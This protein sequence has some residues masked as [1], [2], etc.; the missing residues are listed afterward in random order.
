VTALRW[1]RD[2][3]D[4]RASQ[5]LRYAVYVE[6]MGYYRDTADHLARRW[7]DGHDEAA[8]VLVA[9]VD[10]RDCGTLR[11]HRAGV[12]AIPDSWRDD[13]DL[14]R[15]EAAVGADRV[16]VLTRFVVV[17]SE[18]G[19][20]LPLEMMRETYRMCLGSGVALALIDCVPHLVGLYRRLGFRRYRSGVNDPNT[21][22]LIPMAFDLWDREHLAAL[23]SPL[24]DLAPAD[25]RSSPGI[26]RFFESDNPPSGAFGGLD[27]EGPAPDGLLCGFSAEEKRRV[28]ADAEVFDAVADTILVRRGTVSRCL[29]LVVDG[30]VAVVHRGRDLGRF[31]PGDCFGEMNLLRGKQRSS[32][33]VATSPRTTLLALGERRLERLARHEPQLSSRLYRNIAG[34]LA[35]RLARTNEF[36]P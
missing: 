11:V 4:V 25:G 19:G 26:R 9:A 35:E 20:Y 34:V 1:A 29:Y 5:R 10:G 31:G 36:L 15:A 7:T 16:A 33:V 14:M 22:V 17:A 3:D 6:E 24:V 2:E 32:D 27:L 13:F 21:G 23:G 30:S 12:T 28:L 8:D 18:R